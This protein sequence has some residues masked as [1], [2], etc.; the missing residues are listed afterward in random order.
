[1]AA[2]THTCLH[3][4]LHL[5]STLFHISCALVPPPCPFPW[6]CMAVHTCTFLHSHLCFSCTLM[7]PPCLHPWLHMATHACALFHVS[8][9]AHTSL[10]P[11][12]WL[13]IPAP[14]L[15]HCQFI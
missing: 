11:H 13:C 15:H 8:C 1:M 14:C 7:P 9:A 5:A 10:S 6:L 4:H 12:P 3:P 2:H